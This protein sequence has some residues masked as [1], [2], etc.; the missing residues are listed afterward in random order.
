MGESLLN[1]RLYLNNIYGI[2]NP[3]QVNY[4]AHWCNLMGDPTVEAFVGIPTDLVIAAPDTVP[5]GTSFVD[6]TVTDNQ[7]NPLENVS[8]TLYNS[9]YGNVVSRG[10]TDSQGNVTLNIPNFISSDLLITAAKH[11][12][13]PAQRTLA[14]DQTGALVYFEKVIQDNG[15][16]GSSGNGD[17]FINPDETIAL[18]LEIKNTTANTVTG[19]SAS[20]SSPE[21]FITVLQGNSNYPDL[22]PE[23][24]GSNFV[25]F[26]FSLNN[27]IPT[28]KDCRFELTLTDSASLNHHFIFHLGAYNANL[29]VTNY[30]VSAGGNGILDPA[31]NGILS[32]NVTNSSVFGV[33]EIYGELRSLNDLVQVTDSLSYF[34][35]IPA[36]MTSNSVDGFGIFARPLL[37]PGMQIPFRLRLY[38]SSGFQQDSYFQLPIGSVAQNTPLGPDE[39][40]YFI[41][42]I[43][44]TAF[45]DCP[46]YEWI[47]IVPSLGGSG[48]LITGLNDSGSSGDEGD[49][50]GSDPLETIT[51]PFTFP[52]YGVEYNQITVCV[53]GFI[54]LGVTGDAEFRNGRMPGGQGPS[55]MIAPFWDDLV[56]LSGGGIYRY[57]DADQHILII[58]YQNLK[59]GYN[60][61]SEE[62][63]QVIFYDP[64]FHP[65]SL[66]DGMIKFQYKVFN[67]VDVGGGGYTPQHGNFCTI[68]I[69]DHSNRRGLEY[70]YNNQY[71]Q[72]AQPLGNNKALLV[73]TV[74][75]L[76]QNAHLVV[77]EMILSD[78]NGNGWLEP[79]ESAE[80]GVKLNN[81]GLNAATDVTANVT[82]A[83]PY[84]TFQNAQCTY[85]D[86]PGSGTAINIAPI[87]ITASPDCQDNLVI[88]LELAVTIAGNDW[89]YPLNLT[90]KKPAIAVNGLYINDLQGNANG[91]AEPN[92]T[93]NLI[94]NYI[95]NGSVGAFNLTS[96][97]SC[98]SEEVTI[99]NP[100]QL[101]SAI[102]SGTA[103]Q[104]VYEVSLSPNVIVGNNITFY[105]TYLGDQIAPHNEQI[106]LNVGTTGMLENFETTDGAFVS[107]PS[108]NAWQWGTDSTAGA[109]SGVKVWGTLLN[110]QYPNNVNWTLT[111]PSVYIG[112]NF[113]LEFWHWYNIELNY[114]GGNVKISTNNGSS[115]TLLTPEDGYSQQNVVALNGP[116]FAGASTGWV[117]AR[118]N[119]SAFGNQ[120]VRFRWT[121]AA[122]T[123]VQGQGWYIDDVQTTGFIPSAGKIHGVVTASSP[124]IDY[125]Q[126][127]ILSNTDI[128]TQ[129]GPQGNYVLYLPNGTYTVTASAPGYLEDSVFPVTFNASNMALEHDFY[130][131]LFA[132]VTTLDYDAVE[133]TL[134]LTWAAPADPL[135]PVLSYKVCRRVNAGRYEVLQI[136]TE[137]GYSEVLSLEGSYHY[138]VITVYQ[139]GESLPSNLVEFVFPI[140]DAD[141]PQT[142]GLVTKL[143][144]N[145]PNPF[146]PSTTVMFDLAAGGPVSLGVYNVKG[147]LVRRLLQEALTAGS[148]RVVWDGSDSHNRRVSSGLYFIRLETPAYSQ[149]RKAILMK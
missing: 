31:E 12:C 116:G 128:A 71:P 103:C 43:S 94:V 42:D 8:V 125:D 14:L 133:D 126:I 86:I 4:F 84:L 37:I 5:R 118:F 36:G 148:H 60:R 120:N 80:I 92:E 104:A 44:D 109:H 96:N 95:N 66:G 23:G 22:A 28:F 17:G 131:G 121:F 83:S 122:D 45:P 10:L 107:S 77:G 74:P 11:D 49:Q 67:N 63:F 58:Q 32:L 25:P 105:L 62:T 40:G 89:T 85:P 3:T 9:G 90:I 137:P 93:F 91:L 13:K 61:T 119:L 135:F 54:A 88:N 53:N 81:L 138:Y 68:G 108:T 73:T 48:T 78:A 30:S 87:T 64:V 145:Y 2:S 55:P 132:P 102:P 134:H 72:A 79:G 106:M 39:Y 129:P 1:G 100:Q 38:N 113:V 56:I 27:S 34:G 19:I 33:P 15:N 59:N 46:T 127:L 70:T 144:Q 123:M 112:G 130:L 140:V 7:Q 147:Q 35:A 18:T 69:R 29:A 6:I 82:S 101:I 97:I 110:Q 16:A 114:D 99:T 41:Y 21:S 50:V 24:T 124:A 149:T 136:V 142:P 115:W 98:L 20:L 65:T 75:I 57:Y 143:Y 26:L 141:D 139:A 52:F 146:N 76:H 51:L 47:E 117:L 111:S